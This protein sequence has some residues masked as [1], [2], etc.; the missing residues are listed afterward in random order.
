VAPAGFFAGTAESYVL[1]ESAVVTNDAGFT[2]NDAHTVIDEEALPNLRAGMNLDAEGK[3]TIW[4]ETLG[5]RAQ[6]MRS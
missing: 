3:C 1:I 5:Q 4:E 2:D 6:A